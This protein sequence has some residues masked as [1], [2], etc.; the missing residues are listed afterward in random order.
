MMAIDFKSV[1]PILEPGTLDPDTKMTGLVPSFR[2]RWVSK[3]T[4]AKMQ[5]YSFNKAKAEELLKSIGWKRGAD[6]MWQDKAASRS[7]SRS[8][9]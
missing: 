7:S 6:K 9:R 1:L 2:D 4:L 8:P 5:D 3:E